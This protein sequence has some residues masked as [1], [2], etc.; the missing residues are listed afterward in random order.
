VQSGGSSGASSGGVPL[1][2]GSAA[3]TPAISSRADDKPEGKKKHSE[4]TSPSSTTAA[5]DSPA[6]NAEE[7]PQSS[8][9]G[10]AIDISQ[11]AL[12]RTLS[13]TPHGDLV[14][15]TREPLDLHDEEDKEKEKEKAS[16]V[17]SPSS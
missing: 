6:K 15:S 14:N 8:S 2:K 7:D 10:M 11:V 3:T 4:P 16:D 5:G 1:E 12:T 17:K 9:R 13:F